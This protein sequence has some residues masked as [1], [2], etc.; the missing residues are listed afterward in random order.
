M[1]MSSPAGRRVSALCT[2]S[3]GTLVAIPEQLSPSAEIVKFPHRL[4]GE[5]ASRSKVPGATVAAEPVPGSSVRLTN[6]VGAVSAIAPDRMQ[7]A[8]DLAGSPGSRRKGSSRACPRLV[9]VGGLTEFGLSLPL[10]RI[11]CRARP[12]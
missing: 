5:L 4:E 12:I 2:S 11:V 10:R 6:R 7:S 3:I 8:S 9:R 1:A